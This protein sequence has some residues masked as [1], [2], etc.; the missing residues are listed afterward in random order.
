MSHNKARR[1]RKLEPPSDVTPVIQRRSNS[2]G[3][4]AGLVIAVS[5]LFA[6]SHG[7][8]GSQRL[9]CFGFASMPLAIALAQLHSGYAWSNVTPGSRGVSRTESPR[10][11]WFSVVGHTL[12]ACG[13]IL[14][15][16]L[17]REQR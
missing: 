10:R 15:G 8:V 11:Y 7:E 2:I 1:G 14:F 17:V 9:A 5:F 13:L 3:F 6:A 12:A 16:L 4:W